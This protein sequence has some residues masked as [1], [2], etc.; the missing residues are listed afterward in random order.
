M[1][2]ERWNWS[3]SFIQGMRIKNYT[4]PNKRKESKTCFYRYNK[5][6]SLF[7]KNNKN[8][9]FVVVVSA[10]VRSSVK[11]NLDEAFSSRVGGKKV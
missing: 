8:V 6:L 4:K 2:E 1:S 5:F 7:T 11:S 9:D 10:E 3:L